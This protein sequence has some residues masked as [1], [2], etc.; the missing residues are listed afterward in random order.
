MPMPS[1]CIFTPTYNRAYTL[2]QLYESLCA[3]TCYD[4][5]WLVVDDGSADNTPEL[6]EGYK[7]T[8]PFAMRYLR[9]ANGGKPRAINLGLENAQA[10]LFFVVDS[11]DVLVP[12]AV[13]WICSVW[14]TVKDD[15]GVAGILALCGKSAT[16]PLAGRLPKG[17]SRLKLWDLYERYGFKSDVSLVHRTQIL[18]EYPYEVAEGEKFIAETYV[19]Y[20]IDERFDM[21]A[22]DRIY[23]IREY[24]EDGLTSNFA[25]N[26]KANAVGYMRHKRLCA[27][28]SR[29]FRRRYKETALY[30]VGCM[31][32]HTKGGIASAPSPACAVLAYPAALAL[33]YTVFR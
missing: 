17:V 32:T 1:V 4:F 31:L 24:L 10:E 20:Q 29:T 25:A 22:D 30:L 15:T 11:D 21:V 9:V 27:E 19:Y 16:E 13:E 12:Q 18:R 23:M 3:Q 7:E 8:A 5:E 6:L 2:P 33:R 26:A 28:L 14:E